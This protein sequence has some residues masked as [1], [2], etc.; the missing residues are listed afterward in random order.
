MLIHAVRAD[1]GRPFDCESLARVVANGDAGPLIAAAA[2]HGVLAP[3]HGLVAGCVSDS[4]CREVLPQ[5]KRT[6]LS[7]G[8]RAYQLQDEMLRVL[9]GLDA[10]GVAAMPLKGV[11]LASRLY[12]DATARGCGDLDVLVEEDNLERAENALAELGYRKVHGI[13]SES[14]AVLI[15]HEPRHS[16]FA[17]DSHRTSLEL[18]TE[19]RSGH[20]PAPYSAELLWERAHVVELEETRF[21]YPHHEDLFISLCMHG[22]SHGWNRLMWIMDIGRF[23]AHRSDMDWDATCDRAARIGCERHVLQ[24]LLVAANVLETPLPEQAR[25]R[26]ANHPSL[27]SVAR[28]IENGLFT[29]ERPLVEKI[30]RHVLHLVLLSSPRDR[31][32]HVR[33]ILSP[34]RPSFPIPELPWHQFFP[35]LAVRTVQVFAN[36]LLTVFVDP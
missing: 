35:R 20:S 29:R 30:K 19:I 33:N 26:L 10:V 3:L 13:E 31:M 8:L 2:A 24:A 6:F 11:I 22:M 12:G 17:H 21:P 15:T 5:V 4:R 25:A 7:H 9:K 27:P 34:P 32:R 18:H 1:L 36:K 23:M 28:L 14:P 16:V